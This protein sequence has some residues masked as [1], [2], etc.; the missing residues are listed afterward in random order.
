MS[1]QPHRIYCVERMDFFFIPVYI[2]FPA[3]F[4]GNH[5][6]YERSGRD[7]KRSNFSAMPPLTSDAPI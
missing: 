2:F 5:T 7:G 1:P 3:C 4:T 6:R